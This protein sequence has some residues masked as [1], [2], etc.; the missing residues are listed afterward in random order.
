MFV[1]ALVLSDLLPSVSATNTLQALGSRFM[2]KLG[3]P[4]VHL[5]HVTQTLGT[6]RVLRKSHGHSAQ[7]NNCRELSAAC[8]TEAFYTVSHPEKSPRPK[9]TNRST[10]CP[11]GP[12][13]TK[14]FGRLSS[15]PG[16]AWLLEF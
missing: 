11:G 3:G 13:E 5:M 12:P 16:F 6:L 15:K 8:S 1:V 14:L 10:G 2:V 7:Q 4:A 9:V